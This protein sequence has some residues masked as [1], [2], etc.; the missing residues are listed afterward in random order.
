MF[1]VS[2]FNNEMS[3]ILKYL[4]IIECWR[5]HFTTEFALTTVFSAY[6][7]LLLNS[8]RVVERRNAT[9]AKV[10]SFLISLIFIH[11]YH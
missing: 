1:C 7:K 4:K 5:L 9:A 11:R 8:G 6:E 3:E 2:L 10:S